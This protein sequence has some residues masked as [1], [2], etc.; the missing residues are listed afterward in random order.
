MARKKEMIDILSF[1]IFF[2]IVQVLFY[3]RRRVKAAENSWDGGR[4]TGQAGI[5]NGYYIASDRSFFSLR[6][7]ECLSKKDENEGAFVVV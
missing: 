6:S 5:Y 4:L 2:F 3:S 7:F 1:L